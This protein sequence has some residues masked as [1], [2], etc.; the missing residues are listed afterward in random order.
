MP[1]KRND[2]VKMRRFGR[3]IFNGLAVL[4]LV[5]CVTTAVLWV[6]SYRVADS[7]RMIYFTPYP[8]CDLVHE[9]Y[10]KSMAGGVSLEEDIDHFR[11]GEG[12][13][14][15]GSGWS[16]F[17]TPVYPFFGTRS[18]IASRNHL[19][20]WQQVGF[21]IGNSS[22]G[23]PPSVVRGVILP[24]WACMGLLLITPAL[25]FASNRRR[26]RRIAA[27]LCARCGY[28]LRATPDRCPECGTAITQI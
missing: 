4:S 6:R 15:R 26:Q 17:G 13:K 3:W 24:H 8:N 2:G 12:I 5:L 21:E 9:L 27:G 18:L 22:E 28:D 11:K 16:T 10:F 7:L 23:T 25:W 14:V 1:F 20:V 19:S